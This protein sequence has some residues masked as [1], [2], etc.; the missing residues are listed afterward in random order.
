M[1]WITGKIVNGFFLKL[2]QLDLL[3]SVTGQRN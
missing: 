3:F 2:A 1:F